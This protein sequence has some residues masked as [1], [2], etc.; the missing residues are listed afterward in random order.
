VDDLLA[1]PSSAHVVDADVPLFRV[2]RNGQQP[3][4]ARRVLVCELP[5]STVPDELGA[6]ARSGLERAGIVREGSPL[7]LVHGHVGPVL[8]AP[9]AENRDRYLA[10]HRHLGDAALPA[11]VL[12]GASALGADSLNEQIAAGHWAANRLQEAA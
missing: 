6:A 1:D 9:S 4:P 10:A 7:R 5:W 12:G 2:S 11:L 3:D 8:P